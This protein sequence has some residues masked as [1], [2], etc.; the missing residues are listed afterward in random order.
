MRA[1]KNTASNSKN[2]AKLP[3]LVNDL[4]DLIAN[5]FKE[6]QGAGAEMNE[7]KDKSEE[8]KKK[9]TDKK[10]DTPKTC[11]LECGKEIE[12]SKELE[13]KWKA[14]KKAAKK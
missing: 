8:I 12:S 2:L 5:A 1:V 10:A 6:I 4:K 9:C 7:N 13:K 14:S 11:Y 3:G